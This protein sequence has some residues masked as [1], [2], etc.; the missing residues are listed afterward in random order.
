MIQ[1][2]LSAECKVLST[3]GV[4]RASELYINR[5]QLRNLTRGMPVDRRSCPNH[6]QTPGSSYHLELI[7]QIPCKVHWSA[8]VILKTDV[9]GK[10]LHA[11]IRE[12]LSW[13]GSSTTQ[14]KQPQHLPVATLLPSMASV[15]YGRWHYCTE[16][17]INVIR[18]KNVCVQYQQDRLTCFDPVIEFDIICREYI[19]VISK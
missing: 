13:K 15:P 7:L 10:A 19:L 17:N 8:A 4:S 18:Q 3:T 9:T 2:Q 12:N 14:H 16:G 1:G 6:P 11:L 5:H